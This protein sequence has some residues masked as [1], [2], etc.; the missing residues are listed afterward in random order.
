VVFTCTRLNLYFTGIIYAHVN[1]IIFPLLDLANTIFFQF[2]CCRCR[3][4]SAFGFFAI[5]FFVSCSLTIWQEKIVWSTPNKVI[6]KYLWR[7]SLS[8]VCEIVNILWLYKKNMQNFFNLMLKAYYI[9]HT[10][11]K[12]KIFDPQICTSISRQVLKIE[13][14]FYLLNSINIAGQLC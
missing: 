13:Q 6:L 4:K 10:K 1:K 8:R 9:S 14:I 3:Q 7:V 11:R 5:L 2:L 12:L